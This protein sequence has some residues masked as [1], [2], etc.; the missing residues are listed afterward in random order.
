MRRDFEGGDN[1]RCGEISRKYG[2]LSTSGGKFGGGKLSFRNFY[3]S[4]IF[5]AASPHF[6][7]KGGHILLVRVVKN[8]SAITQAGSKYAKY[9]EIHS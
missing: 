3:V 7:G 2:I 1:S 5:V 6:F 8:V 4:L 9:N